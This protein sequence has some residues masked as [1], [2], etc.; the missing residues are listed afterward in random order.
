MVDESVER[1]FNE[2]GGTGP[3][4]T[5]IAV[6]SNGVSSRSHDGLCRLYL[7]DLQLSATPLYP[8]AVHSSSAAL[9]SSLVAVI[10]PSG[11]LLSAHRLHSQLMNNYQPSCVHWNR[12]HTVYTPLQLF[13]WTRKRVPN[14]YERRPPVTT[15]R[16][17]LMFNP[18]MM[19]FIS[20]AGFSPGSLD[21]SQW[22]FATLS[23]NGFAL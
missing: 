23:E 22:N 17:G 11:R 20:F 7:W 14:G 8:Q 15:V 5:S 2:P 19:F 12:K 9:V 18:P 21:R 10:S 3:Y 1:L 16:N 6:S 13:W 4:G